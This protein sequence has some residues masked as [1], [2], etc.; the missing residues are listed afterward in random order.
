MRGG[1][2]VTRLLPP[3]SERDVLS[4]SERVV[5]HYDC[6]FDPSWPLPEAARGRFESERGRFRLFH[7]AIRR[8][9]ELLARYT[10]ELNRLRPPYHVWFWCVAHPELEWQWKN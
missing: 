2:N 4:A 5:R 7:D 8:S 10:A 6:L 9:P 3:F 1:A